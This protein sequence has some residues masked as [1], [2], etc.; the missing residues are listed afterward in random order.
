VRLIPHAVF[1]V[2]LFAAYLQLLGLGFVLKSSKGDWATLTGLGLLIGSF[3]VITVTVFI[4]GRRQVRQYFDLSYDLSD[5]DVIAISTDCELRIDDP[6]GEKAHY[7]KTKTIRAIRH[8]LIQYEE[9]GIWTDG[10]I[11]NLVVTCIP[12]TGKRVISHSIIESG[13]LQ[14]MFVP[15]LNAME[16][17]TLVMEWDLL[18]S[19]TGNTECFT[20]Q[21]TLPPKRYHLRI[22]F[23]KDRS[24]KDAW[25]EFT[26]DRK[27]ILLDER[28]Y[29]LRKESQVLDYT[30]DYIR[31][32]I[33]ST[34]F[35]EW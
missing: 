31:P 27:H 21:F 25:V 9:K 19:F 4:V 18:G 34:V 17:Q 2:L 10:K 24:Y 3:V 26:Y 16:T 6:S 1:R 28:N 33:K 32:G 22:Y 11:D 35:W 13:D 20:T 15:P 8:N 14:I 30:V 12:P 23:P 29:Q 5:F 7:K